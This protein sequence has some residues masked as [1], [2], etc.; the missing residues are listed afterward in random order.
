M[1]HVQS[2]F[3]SSPPASPPAPGT[4]PWSRAPRWVARRTTRTSAARL[5]AGEDGENNAKMLGEPRNMQILAQKLGLNSEKSWG[6]SR[7]LGTWQGKM[8]VLLGKVID[9]TNKTGGVACK[10]WWLNQQKLWPYQQ[11]RQMTWHYMT[12]H[13]NT[14]QHMTWHCISLGFSPWHYTTWHYLTSHPYLWQLRAWE[15]E[16]DIGGKKSRVV[17]I[18]AARGH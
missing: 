4:S 5:G 10:T 14:L 17:H 13:G 9:L 6:L 2:L 1:G 8:V 11:H 3:G 15:G 7:K 12:L 16:G 18:H